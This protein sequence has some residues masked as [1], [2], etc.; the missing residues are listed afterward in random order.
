MPHPGLQAEIM[1]KN[2]RSSL[3]LLRDGLPMY[4]NLQNK[5]FGG[6]SLEE[7][8]PEFKIGD[9]PIELNFFAKLD[10]VNR[11]YKITIKFLASLVDQNH[12]LDHLKTLASHYTLMPPTIRYDNAALD[13]GLEGD[14]TYGGE[15]TTTAMKK[16]IISSRCK[17]KEDSFIELQF[18]IKDQIPITLLFKRS[19]SG[20][21]PINSPIGGIA[22]PKPQEQTRS[23]L[24]SLFHLV[25]FVVVW[26]LKLLLTIAGMLGLAVLVDHFLQGKLLQA[27]TSIAQPDSKVQ[28]KD[29]VELKPLV[30]LKHYGTLN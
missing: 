6:S 11:V 24:G 30:T 5:N 25:V 2:S 9:K 3:P 20:L 27:A 19:C 22:T 1:E 18:G 8:V 21:V 16:L 17:I 13:V 15:I 23:L 10:D 14:F 28:K 12:T 26:S 4:P 29:A 7:L